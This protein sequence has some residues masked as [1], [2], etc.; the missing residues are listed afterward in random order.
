MDELARREELVKAMTAVELEPAVVNSEI[1]TGRYDRL[2]LSRLTALGAGLEPVTAAIQQIVSHGQAV[3][4]YYKVTIPPGGS[5]C[6]VQGQGEVQ[7]FS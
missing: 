6:V 3:R 4:G 2:P 7:A 5:F 1:T